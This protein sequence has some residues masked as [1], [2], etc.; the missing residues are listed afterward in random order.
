MSRFESALPEPLG[1]ILQRIEAD[2]GY[3]GSVLG[4]F[5]APSRKGPRVAA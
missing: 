1:T 4:P 5:L 2:R 3:T